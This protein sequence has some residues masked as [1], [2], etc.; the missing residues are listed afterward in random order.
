MVGAEVAIIAEHALKIPEA[1]CPGPWVIYA[2]LLARGG[3]YARIYEK[4]FRPQEKTEPMPLPA[5]TA[6]Q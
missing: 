4:Q 6:D 1:R 3:L 2:Q 5:S